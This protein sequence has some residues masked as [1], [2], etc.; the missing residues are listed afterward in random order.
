M[1]KHFPFFFLVRVKWSLGGS[2]YL[3]ESSTCRNMVGRSSTLK[4]PGKLST[5]FSFEE[6][7][8]Q[9]SWIWLTWMGC[10]SGTCEGIHIRI[11]F[12][13]SSN[14]IN[15][16]MF[17]Y[18][19]CTRLMYNFILCNIQNFN[20]CKSIHVII[21]SYPFLHLPRGPPKVLSD[22][23]E[24][25][26]SSGGASFVKNL[27]SQTTAFG[28]V[29][30]DPGFSACD[31]FL[32]TFVG[33]WASF[34]PGPQTGRLRKYSETRRFQMAYRFGIIIFKSVYATFKGAYC[35]LGWPKIFQGTQKSW[36]A[37]S[38][39]LLKN[40][41]VR[42]GYPQ[43]RFNRATCIWFDFDLS[44]TSDPFP[45]QQIQPPAVGWNPGWRQVSP[46]SASPARRA[47]CALSV[48]CAWCGCVLTLMES[49]EKVISPPGL[50]NKDGKAKTKIY[51][52]KEKRVAIISLHIICDFLS[53]GRGYGFNGAKTTSR[54]LQVGQYGTIFVGNWLP[55]KCHKGWVVKIR[56]FSN[57]A[58]WSEGGCFWWIPITSH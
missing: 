48:C 3:K 29:E 26:F 13:T 54:I 23:S 36:V 39:N 44:F 42:Q 56:G 11:Q 50:R 35:R 51:Q 33:D 53:L 1:F 27:A 34:F 46:C 41:L 30:V 25:V 18:R 21:F 15:H 12:C 7:S 37:Q 57:P 40:Y 6:T 9:F 45:S 55:G 24:V 28:W 38:N 14:V 47:S 20:W 43:A 16:Y 2:M 10:I 31:F 5:F 49:S 17:I 22:W 8:K 4:L 52:E 32:L 19:R 58:P